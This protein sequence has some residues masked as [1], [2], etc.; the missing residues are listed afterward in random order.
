VTVRR[1]R[2]DIL[3]DFTEAFKGR[4]LSLFFL[5]F[6]VVLVLLAVTTGFQ[7]P[8]LKQLVVD[9]SYRRS[10]LVLGLVALVLGVV[11]YYFPGQWRT[12][13]WKPLHV[14]EDE[15][16]GQHGRFVHHGESGGDE[17]WE[18][19]TPT[20]VENAVWGPSPYRPLQRGDYCAVFRLMI[21]DRSGDEY[22]PTAWIDV[23]SRQAKKRLGF[24]DLTVRDFAGVNAFQD[25]PLHFTLLQDESDVEF[26]VSKFGDNRRLTLDHIDLSRHGVDPDGKQPKGR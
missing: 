14:K 7:V 1:Q 16:Q 3:T 13:V 6:G 22:P 9:E 10:A 4:P 25:F 12:E 26:H 23:T 11:F 15:L 18:I 5:V 20:Y 2:V 8:G 17:A 24:R 21:D 19:S